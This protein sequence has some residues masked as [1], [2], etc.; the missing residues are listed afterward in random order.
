VA[1]PL[2]WRIEAFP[3][4][5]IRLRP[6]PG[7]VNRQGRE[8]PTPVHSRFQCDRWWLIVLCPL[9]W[10]CAAGYLWPHAIVGAFSF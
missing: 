1:G 10:L 2:R 5:S 7:A 3:V 8:Y 4:N 9:L 6:R